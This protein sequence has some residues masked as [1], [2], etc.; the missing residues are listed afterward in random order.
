M[1]KLYVG[2]LPY[3]VSEE[4]LINLFQDYGTVA[5]CKLISDNY[6]GQSKGFAFIEMGSKEEAEAA[7]DSLNSTE[8]GGRTIKVN[9]A[10]EKQRSRSTNSRGAAGYNNRR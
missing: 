6:T 4:D 3:S 9:V 1:S 10:I 2:N 8:L 7:I 5:S